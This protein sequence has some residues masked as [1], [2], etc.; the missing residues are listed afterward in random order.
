M[1]GNDVQQDLPA[2]EAGMGTFLVEGH[3][4]DR[5]TS[6]RE[7]DSRGSLEELG[8]MLGIKGN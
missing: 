1:I 8:E 2:S 6:Y 7:P 5:G 3:L 4:V